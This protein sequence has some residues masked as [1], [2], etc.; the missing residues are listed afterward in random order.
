MRADTPAYDLDI[1]TDE[2]RIRAALADAARTPFWLEDPGRPVPLPALIGTID[3]DLLIIG[4]GY[5]GLWTALQAKEADPARDVVLVEG[6]EI[7]W[8]ASGRNGGFVEASLTHGQEN[9]QRY[10]GE[11]LAVLEGL[12]EENFAGFRD[13]L[14]R[15]GIDA[16]WEENGSLAVATER[17]QVEE[18]RAAPGRFYDREQLAGIVK[19]PLFRAG[20]FQETGAAL[21]HPAKLA[22][23]LKDACRRLGVRI[24]EHTPVTRLT[25]RGGTV[26]ATTR[27]GVVRARQV[28]LATNG[29]P[30]L[31]RRNR[32]LTIPIYDYVLMTEPLTPAQ[33]DEIGWHGRFGIGD[34]SR[35][36]HYYRK[37]ADN[38]ILWGGYDAVY[39]RGGDIRPEFDQRPETFARLA[40]HFLRTFPQLGEIR[41]TH[42][43]GGMI[44]MSTRLAAFQGLAMG[45][46]VAYASGFTG[47]G[48]AATRF[49]GAVMLDLLAGADT[50]RT[51]LRMATR[52]PM[53]IPPE[54]IAYPAVQVIRRAIA[55]ADRNGGRDGL[56]LKTANLFGFSFDS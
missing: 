2:K 53:P 32:M 46:K 51:R 44:D 33:L 47:L 7:G 54:P 9:G 48:V 20:S 6:E 8:A 17:H 41:F 50:P 52:R 38:R 21:V 39:H 15:H 29:F 12:A 25:D 10:F 19:S 18:L 1:R 37:S 22:W 16:E 42:A 13:S 40:D 5:C 27:M 3:T 35:Q 31:L 4:G 23:G 49:A 55:R 45:G 56:I 36:F 34:C 11:D 26:R 28:V 24:Y 43:W 14:T 30:S